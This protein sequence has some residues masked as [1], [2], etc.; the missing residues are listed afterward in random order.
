MLGW[1][2]TNHFHLQWVYYIQWQHEVER[3]FSGEGM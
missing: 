3:Q 2:H 1:R